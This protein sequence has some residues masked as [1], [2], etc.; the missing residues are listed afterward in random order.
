MIEATGLTKRYGST[1]AVDDLTFRVADGRVTGFLGPNGAGKSTTMRL[2]VGL[3]A[4][5]SGR[6]TVNGL[7]VRDRHFPLHEVG[8]LLEAKAIHPSRSARNHL[9]WL[10]QSNGIS[11][12]RVDEVLEQVG[13][14]SVARKRAGTFSLGMSQRLGIAA[15]LLG[16]PEVLLLDEPVNGLD[17]EGI[18]WVR[19][20]LRSLASEGRTVFVSSHLMSEMALTADHLIVIGKGRLIADASVEE[21]I[22]QAS[23]NHVKVVSP[24]ADALRARVAAAGADVEPAGDDTLIV[25]GLECREVGIIAAGAGITLYELSRQEASLEEAFMEM[26]RDS[27]EYVADP[28]AAGSPA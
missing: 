14:T 26:T 1:L 27:T 4:A 24:Q 23:A 20:L 6:V 16:D 10:A 9:R 17:P 28:S 22:A 21:V 15:A 11:P 25:T 2:I 5:S 7:A 3:D 8:A 12:S 13:L 18:Q 19:R